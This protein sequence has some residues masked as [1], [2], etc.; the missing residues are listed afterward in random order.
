M[1]KYLKIGLIGFSI[2]N[3]AWSV[4]A[5]ITTCFSP[6]NN[7]SKELINAIRNAKKTI[8]VQSYSFTNHDIAMALV[9]AKSNGVS[10]RVYIDKSR[11]KEKY[12]IIHKMIEAK[13]PVIVQKSNNLAHNKIMI[14]DDEIVITGSFNWTNNALKNEENL[15]FIKSK[16]LVRSYLDNWKEIVK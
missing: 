9:D 10:V 7:C 4:P 1:N 8:Y 16:A 14:I 13:I 5:D 11:V 6:K 12:C 2:I 3:P 15:N